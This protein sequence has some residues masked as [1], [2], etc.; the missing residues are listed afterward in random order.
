MAKRTWIKSSDGTR[1][2][3]QKNIKTEDGSSCYGFYD[4]ATGHVTVGDELVSI[5]ERTAVHEAVHKSFHGMA[6]PDA[7]KIFGKD[8]TDKWREE[9]EEAIAN[10][11]DSRV[12]DVLK[13]WRVIKFVKPPKSGK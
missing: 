1:L 2:Y 7:E 11:I 8:Y 3:V 13:N 12:F 5:M 9:C 10:H 6:R 4:M